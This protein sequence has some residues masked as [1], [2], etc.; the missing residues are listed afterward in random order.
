VRGN[1]LQGPVAYS[2]A[3]RRRL[4]TVRGNALQAPVTYSAAHRRQLSTL[5]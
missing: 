5:S 4:S 2:A 1:A 3:H